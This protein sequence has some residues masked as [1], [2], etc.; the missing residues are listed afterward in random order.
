MTKF[1][2]QTDIKKKYS[3]LS[4]KVTS[5]HLTLYSYI[6][7]YRTL[8]HSH[9][10][11]LEKLQNVDFELIFSQPLVNA[12][13]SIVAKSNPSLYKSAKMPLF[14]PNFHMQKFSLPCLS[15]ICYVSLMCEIYMYDYTYMCLCI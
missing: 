1:E 10:E 7:L 5:G 8:S 9:A 13:I 6:S 2:F 12:K 4:C 14:S 11:L 15:N 3:L